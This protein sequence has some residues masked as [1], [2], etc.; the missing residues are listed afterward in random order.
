VPSDPFSSRGDEKRV[1]SSHQT[2]F[3][4]NLVAAVAMPFYSLFLHYGTMEP[5][6]LNAEPR[7]YSL[8]GRTA[9]TL[10]SRQEDD[11]RTAVVGEILTEV[12]EAHLPAF[13]LTGFK[14]LIFSP[15][16]KIHTSQF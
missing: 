15:L 13:V 12:E 1:I 6:R 14:S 7:F 3:C 4:C 5:I 10:A 8:L 11:F 16:H 9:P 2:A